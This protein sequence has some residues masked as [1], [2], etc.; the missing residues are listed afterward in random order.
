MSAEIRQLDHRVGIVLAVLCGVTIGIVVYAVAHPI[1]LT[2]YDFEAFWC[3]GKA[4]LQHANPYA[5][6]PLHTCEATTLPAFFVH[7]PQVTIPVP[8]PGYAI[9]LFTPFALV[10]FVF[11]RAA[12]WI[13]QIVCA[14]VI[15]RGIAKLSGMST[16]TAVAAS[17]LAVLG[18]AI[19]QEALSPIPIALSVCAALALQRK[20]WNA[21]TVL[22][23]FAMI[24]PHMV[25]PACAAV[26]LF[27]QEMRVRL[28]VAG[29][30]AV[31]IM[32]VAIGPQVALSYFTTILP[33]HAAS[34]VSNLGQDSLTA[35]LYRL[36][37]RPAL[38][39]HLGSL[40]YV[41]LAIGGLFVARALYQKYGDRSWLVLVPAAFAVTGGA[42]IHLDEVAMAIPLACVIA[43]RRPGLVS[44][45][46]L[47]MLALPVESIVGWLPWSV[48]AAMICIW[49]MARP[50]CYL[51]RFVANGILPVAVTLVL[52]GGAFALHSI[53]AA[54]TQ[55]AVMQIVNFANPGGAASASV[56]WSAY[57]A[58]S[59]MTLLWWPEKLWTLLPLATLAG[60][61]VREAFAKG[62]VTTLSTA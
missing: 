46:V 2:G 18:P 33:L 39:L 22:L 9:A 1:R 42:F 37:V 11:A 20:Q 3:G 36:G 59:K 35:V 61:C 27:V 32:L 8:L 10:P 56:T 34:E 40:Q 6:E 17:A 28:V 52:L 60:L 19:M 54:D 41:V 16:V 14:F 51:K 23:G 12:W 29:A 13:L 31:A 24:E 57:N 48:P 15:A 58:L 7:Y 62:R 26:F 45:L 44:A 53:V 38:A 43:M 25:L 21:A 55:Q 5:N 4:L 47:V 50:G 49:F 30:C